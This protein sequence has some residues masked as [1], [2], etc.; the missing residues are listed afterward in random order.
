MFSFENNP[1]KLGTKINEL[2]VKFE[3]A[4]SIV[5]SLPGI[6]MSL[7]EQEAYYAELLQQYKRET[8]LIESYKEMCRFDMQK[9]ENM[10]TSFSREAAS[11]SEHMSTNASAC[12]NAHAV[13]KSEKQ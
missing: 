12:E 3:K 9:L 13:I 7:K 6:D 2:K 1:A 10:P 11:T 4:R 5:A 8:E